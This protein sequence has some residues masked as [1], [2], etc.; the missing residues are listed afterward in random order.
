MIVQLPAS[1]SIGSLATIWGGFSRL[2]RPAG[3]GLW[4]VFGLHPGCGE[5]LRL[6]PTVL[7]ISVDGFRWDY[8]EKAATP[9]LDRLVA[10][11]VTAEALIPVFP[12]KTF[13]NHYSIVTGLFPTNHGVVGNDMF[14][15]V[16]TDTFS[17]GNRA[18]VADGRWYDGEPIWVTAEQQGQR[19]A[20]I[21]WPGSE[22]E[23][24]GTRPSYWLAYDHW[25]SHGDKVQQLLAQ[26]DL[27]PHLRPTFLTMYFHDVDGAGH[28]GQDSLLAAAISR[29]DSTLGILIQ[30]LMDRGIM[31]EIN[32]IIVSDHGMAGTD[33]IRTIFVDDYMELNQAGI[34]HM[35]PVLA[36]RPAE[37]V[38][39]QVYLALKNAHP[40]LRVYWRTDLPA[41]LHYST[42]YRIP[43]IVALADEGWNISSHEWRESHHVDASWGE[44]G[45]DNRYASMWGIFIG[46]GPAFKN[47]LKVPPFQNIHLYTLMCEILDLEPAPNDG[48][49]DT[50]KVLL[51]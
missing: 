21:F 20:P 1:P 23:I 40:N 12:T 9:N 41:R 2:L 28:Q 34:V 29:V 50:V 6:A 37:G 51:D 25:M 49:L 3:L 26:L 35:S 45:Y 10:T 17:L 16:F 15:P 18:A 32:I 43:P 11:G 46:R 14:D 4:L 31:E 22:A 7:L 48:S 27:P 38:H 5:P 36:L 33:S 8:R 24:K 44:H 42:H 47:G 13:P 39:E 19:T 30:G